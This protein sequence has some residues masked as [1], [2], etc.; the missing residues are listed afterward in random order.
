MVEETSAAATDDYMQAETAPKKV[1]HRKK[2]LYHAILQQMEFYF[3]DSNLLKDRFL[4]KLVHD[5]GYVDLSVF[6]T[7]N[8][9]RRL[10]SSVEDLAKALKNSEMLTVSEDG[11]KICRVTPVK[12][13]ENVD[14][15]TIYVEQLPPDADH[16]WLRGIFSAY[17]KVAYVSIPKYRGSGKVK[18]FAFVEFDTPEE[19]N[20][21]LE[22]FG[23]MG[24]CLPTEIPPEQLCSIST[25]E[26]EDKD[27]CEL[28]KDEEVA[29]EARQEHEEQQPKKKR[30]RNKDCDEKDEE[31]LEQVE[32]PVTK[33]KR[34]SETVEEIEENREESDKGSSGNVEEKSPEKKKKKKE[35]DSLVSP[36][37]EPVETSG[38]RKKRKRSGENEQ[39]GA[40]DVDKHEDKEDAA[41]QE[42][43]DGCRKR[44]KGEDSTDDQEGEGIPEEGRKKKKNRKRKKK[45]KKDKPET[46]GTKI[47]LRILSK[48]E[49][50]RLRNKY[51]ELQ[52]KKMKA[53]KQYLARSRWA[54]I[55]QDSSQGSGDNVEV[56]DDAKNGVPESQARTV[57]TPGVIVHCQ[58]NTPVD[59][60]KKFKADARVYPNV[61]YVDVKEGDTEVFLR[62]S[63]AEAAKQLVSEKPW[64][65][66]S[67]IEG[68]EE[69]AY[70]EKIKRDREEKLGKKVRV[71]QRGRD[72]LLKKAETV[73]GKHMRFDDLDDQDVNVN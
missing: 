8:R 62:C 46:D 53:F 33:K 35:A 51:L 59:D 4:G 21:T 55:K 30:K 67:V 15:C 48:R 71:K 47:G 57:F 40:E 56:E 26:Q 42:D 23:A 25:F 34:K 37:T 28:P 63:S 20:R 27:G 38:R 24:C 22:A 49:W 3:S 12:V 39:A 72:R 5:S 52:R 1:R 6:L 43:D 65:R 44:L 41:E 11:T 7:F 9:I 36:E 58:L 60:V 70:W 10:T 13:K 19:A 29:A 66:M 50:K 69:M 31:S 61:K 16:D 18:G 14:D 32:A 54:Q 64:E 2:K 68:E 17:G 45:N 73:L